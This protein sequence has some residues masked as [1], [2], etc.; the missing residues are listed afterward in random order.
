[1][2]P[3]VLKGISMDEL[4]AECLVQL[5]SMSN[6]SIFAIIEGKKC[7]SST[8]DLTVKEYSIIADKSSTTNVSEKRSI[9]G[10]PHSPLKKVKHERDN[11]TIKQ[12]EP[13]KYENNFNS[14]SDE[15]TTL[16]RKRKDKK[17]K[18]GKKRKKSGGN[19]EKDNDENKGK[20]LLELLELEMRAK[21]IRSLLKQEE[22]EELKKNKIQKEECDC[23]KVTPSSSKSGKESSRLNEKTK[24]N[25]KNDITNI[26][27]KNGNKIITASN[28]QYVPN[29]KLK[30]ETEK[31]SQQNIKEVWEKS[32]STD[33][34]NISEVKIKRENYD[35]SAEEEK[36]IYEDDDYDSDDRLENE[37]NKV[38]E[39]SEENSRSSWAERWL[40]S[41][42]VKRVVATSKMLTVVRNKMK[43]SFRSGMKQTA[44]QLPSTQPEIEGSV[45]EYDTLIQMHEAV[46]ESGQT[47]MN[48][49]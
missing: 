23:H 38:E 20:S 21:A 29:T 10:D 16:K 5:L 27:K 43:N 37:T 13:K 26:S 28:L 33:I 3:T 17:H 35:W 32:L 4:K 12:D 15:T 11:Q 6:A 36:L 44:T 39:K 34:T 30:T 14:N 42:D 45:K 19:E 49:T 31:Q 24:S 9:S 40:Q 48:N 8:N 46:M 2:I 47:S 25:L 22:E 41:K 18:T 7:Y 1:M